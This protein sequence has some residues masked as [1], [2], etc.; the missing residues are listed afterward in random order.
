[1]SQWS[2]NLWL[3]TVFL[4]FV[5]LI[6]CFH[7]QLLTEWRRRRHSICHL[8]GVYSEALEPLAT[9]E[10]SYLILQ[11]DSKTLYLD[12]LRGHLNWCMRR[13]ELM[14]YISVIKSFKSRGPHYTHLI[15]CSSPFPRTW[16]DWTLFYELWQIFKAFFTSAEMGF[17]QVSF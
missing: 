6:T 11:F 4:D 1:M 16:Y 8:F 2:H 7:Y 3:L 15:V 14:Y 17:K 10:F 13:K 12:I 9:T 5:C